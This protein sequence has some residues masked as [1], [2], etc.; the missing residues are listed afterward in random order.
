LGRR[1][2]RMIDQDQETSGRDVPTRVAGMLD[3]HAV[4]RDGELIVERTHRE[5]AAGVGAHE[6]HVAKVLRAF[7]QE[8]LIASQRGRAGLVIRDAA[9]LAALSG[10]ES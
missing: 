2:V 1:L 4:E 9:G 7:R 6:H 8:G 10:R 3:E 5:I